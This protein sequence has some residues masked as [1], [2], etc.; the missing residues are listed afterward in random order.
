MHKESI[1]Q[2]LSNIQQVRQTLAAASF[3]LA[4]SSAEEAQAKVKTALTQ[5]DDYILP[6]L[7]SLEAPLTLV[8]GGSTGAGKSTL[9]NTLVGEPVTRSG[10]IRPTTRQPVLLHRPED[11]EAF[12]PERILPNLV[13]IA[14]EPGQALPGANPHSGQDELV[15]V[16]VASL[17]AGIALI[18]AP[19]F[20]S[21]SEE[22]RRLAQQLLRAADLWLFV[23]TANRYADALPWEILRQAAARDITIA[24]VLNR[25]PEGS[26]DEIEADL[27]RMLAEAGISPAL[28]HSVTEQE[29]DEQGLL[30]S[31]AL[32][33]L[34]F[35]LRTLGADSE[36]RSEIVRRTLEGALRSLGQQ[37]QDLSQAAAEQEESRNYLQTSLTRAF[38]EAQDRLRE[39][40][41]DGQMLRGEVLTRWQDFVGTGEF[42]RQV[43]STIGKVRD[44]MV[45]FFTGT[46]PT[47]AVEVEEALEIG[48]HSII[49]EEIAAA[50]ERA[51]RSWLQ[52]RAG[53]ALLAGEDLAALGEGFS[54]EVAQSIRAWQQD[55]MDIIS[56]EGAGKRQKARFMS[57]GL[58]AAAL[59]L[60]VAVFS[61]T[62]GL[63]GLE[64]GIAG[65]SGLIGQKLLEAIFG[66]DAVR[67]MATDARKRLD[68]RIQELLTLQQEPFTQRLS[69]A[70]NPQ[71]PQ[72]QDLEQAAQLLSSASQNL[73]SQNLASQASSP[74][75]QTK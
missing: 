56:Q 2:T 19:D 38:Q 21:V 57:L 72:A 46:P 22:N 34:I 17:P 33:P 14:L 25:V 15:T 75:A 24:V 42:F 63:T 29:R 36:A 59:T 9:V 12:S 35:W 49:M 55:L 4:N 27:T 67:R 68:A 18:D 8:V 10:A 51:Q 48:L 69:Q 47:R 32:T 20:D 60:M 37:T 74:Q 61:M 16:P 62:G 73:A 7:A 31:V 64:V 50:A 41:Q 11:A 30:P 53:R 26:E 52:D 58:N 65:G 23:T 3:P 70:L 6:K 13:R 43:E 39:A 28:I 71:A 66:E 45:G 5:L 54:E 1:I 40:T 44:R